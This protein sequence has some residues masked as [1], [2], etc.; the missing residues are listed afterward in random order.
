MSIAVMEGFVPFSAR[1]ILM[2][3]HEAVQKSEEIPLIPATAAIHG[4]KAGPAFAG[5]ESVPETHCVLV[6]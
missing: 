4:P 2:G 1:A 5:K 6:L 3:R